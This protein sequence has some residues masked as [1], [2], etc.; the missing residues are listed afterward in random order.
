MENITQN[1]TTTTQPEWM[2]LFMW[3]G[4]NL[5]KVVAP[6]LFFPGTVFNILIIVVLLFQ[7]FGKSSTRVPLIVLALSDA[8]L[9][10]MALSPEVFEYNLVGYLT[11]RKI[12]C[13]V[14]YYF[15][16]V[17]MQY[18]SWVITLVTLERWISVRFPLNSTVDRV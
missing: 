10:F 4:F 1:T 12:S 8:I 17:I 3:W 16:Y 9:L 18:S 5:G 13:I 7:K 2:I 15:E 6:V 14:Y 11:N